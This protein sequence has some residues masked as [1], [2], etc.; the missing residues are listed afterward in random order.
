MVGRRNTFVYLLGSYL[1]ALLMLSPLS[2]ATA[3]EA[4]HDDR[5]RIHRYAPFSVQ[6]LVSYSHRLDAT[7][8]TNPRQHIKVGVYG[9]QLALSLENNVQLQQSL[10]RNQ[11]SLLR[12][13]LDGA[14]GS[15]VRLTTTVTGTHGLI[16]DGREMYAVEPGVEIRDQLAHS[17]P[18]PVTDTVI[19][20]LAD[21]TMDFGNDYCGTAARSEA[22]PSSGQAVYQALA[23]DLS[24]TPAQAAEPTL[25][26]EMQVLADAAFR[27]EFQSDQQA[28]DAIAVRLNNVDGI[29]TAQMGL[30]IVASDVHLYQSDPLGLSDSSDAQTLLNSLGQLRNSKPGMNSYAATHLFTGRDLDGDTLGIAYIGNV[31]ST[32]YGASL[33]EIRNRGAWIDSLV[34]AHELGHQLGAVHD[35]TGSCAGTPAQSY[36][37]GAQI[38]GS[39]EFS[40]CSREAILATMQN[41]SCLLPVSVPNIGDVMAQPQNESA[42]S[43]GGGAFGMGWWWLG[44]LVWLRKKAHPRP[45]SAQLN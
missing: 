18:A 4:R 40:Q 9:R 17:L 31:C 6:D 16:W 42:K 30:R 21:T 32:R 29:F 1:L 14:P 41:A 11:A 20:K 38:N 12:G 39:S 45:R 37:M 27:A 25:I 19:F 22:S 36:L 15:W 7:S 5:L 13:D 28:L 33:S 44:T 3:G 10:P 43:S 34:A 2:A 8:D 23:S 26:L 24:Q 35:G